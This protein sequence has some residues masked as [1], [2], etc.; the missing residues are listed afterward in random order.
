MIEN[1]PFMLRLSKH[2]VPFQKVASLTKERRAINDGGRYA[3]SCIH[4]ESLAPRFGS[5]K[6][7]CG[8]DGWSRARGGVRR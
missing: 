4:C 5:S 8:T 6:R 3:S 1:I 2:E 7:S